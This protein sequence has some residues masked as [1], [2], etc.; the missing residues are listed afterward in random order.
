MTAK[1]F[2]ANLMKDVGSRDH[3]QYDMAPQVNMTE[4]D[5]RPLTEPYNPIYNLIPVN[6]VIVKQYVTRP[7]T[8]EA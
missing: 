2:V 5:H 1:L 7:L 6:P 3:H 8:T 4:N